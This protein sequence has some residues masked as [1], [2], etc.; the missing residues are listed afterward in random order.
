[1]V[2]RRLLYQPRAKVT[3]PEGYFITFEGE[4][5]AQ[6]DATQ[7]IVIFSAVVFFGALAVCIIA[8]VG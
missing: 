4:F 5:Q 3:F 1:M 2:G 7:R 6:Q 8:T